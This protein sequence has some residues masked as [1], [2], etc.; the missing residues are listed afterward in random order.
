[1]EQK[2]HGFRQSDNGKVAGY[3]FEKTEK[4]SEIESGIRDEKISH[5]CNPARIHTGAIACGLVNVQPTFTR[6]SSARRDRERSLARAC[7][8]QTSQRLVVSL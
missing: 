7:L 1:M 6:N 3:G 5:E 4:I 2:N 8:A